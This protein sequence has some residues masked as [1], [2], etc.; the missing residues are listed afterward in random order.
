MICST[1]SDITPKETHKFSENSMAFKKKLNFL[2]LNIISFNIIYH[3][4]HNVRVQPAQ[5]NN[6]AENGAENGR[7]ISARVA[8][9]SA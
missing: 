4:E 3:G 5:I 6:G 1:I 8:S 2:N 9:G 7:K